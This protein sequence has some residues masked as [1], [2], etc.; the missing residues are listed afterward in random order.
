[1]DTFMDSSWYWYRYLNPDYADGPFDPTMKRWLP[2]DQYTGGIEHATMH[3]LYARFFTMAMRDMGMVEFDEPFLRLFN[4]GIILGEDSEKMS[5]SRGN[6]MDPDDLVHEYGAD[7]VRLFLMFLGPW[8]QG[9]PWNS[10]GI[11]GPQRFLDRAFA[12]VI[13]TA[14]NPAE[15]RDD[16]ATRNL[17][18]LTHQTIGGVTADIEVFGFNTAIAKLMEFVNELMKAK[19]TPVA[20]TAAWREATESLALMLAPFAPHIAEELWHR[21]GKPFSVH[22]QSWPAWDEELA[23]DE[24]IEVAV[25]V[26]GKVRDRITLP[27]G[28]TDSDALAAARASARVQEHLAGKD[29]VKEIHVPGRLISFVV[30]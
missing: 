30:R 28:A 11:A 9:G 17:R 26:N 29:V 15:A 18:R 7:T 4:Q 3:L 23:A 10:R 12:V 8:D 16:E 14:G 22:T 2:V 24:T 21:L 19:D 5:K 27:A 25:Q 13:E 1:M 20:S 6:V